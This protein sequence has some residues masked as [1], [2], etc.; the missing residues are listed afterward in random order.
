MDGRA[1]LAMTACLFVVVWFRRRDAAGLRHRERSV[2][3]QGCGCGAMDGRASLAMTAGLVVASAFVIANEVRR[4]TAPGLRHR[5][6]SVAIQGPNAGAW[7]AAL[8]SP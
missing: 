7:M 8:R 1:S 4:S 6:G 5:E 3:I 2:A